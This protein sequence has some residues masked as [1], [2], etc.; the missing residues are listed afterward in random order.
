[1]GGECSVFCVRL[2]TTELEQR[3]RAVGAVGVLEERKA[4]GRWVYQTEQE[5]APPNADPGGSADYLYYL[6]IHPSVHPSVYIS[7]SIFVPRLLGKATRGSNKWL[8][9]CTHRQM[10][11][12]ILR[13]TPAA[14]RFLKAALET[15][16]SKASLA[17]SKI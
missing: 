13:K 10:H 1:M 6:S 14:R 9:E 4:C 16:S 7:L 3:R 8:D 17:A 15:R 12:Y 5:G 11:Y 2:Q